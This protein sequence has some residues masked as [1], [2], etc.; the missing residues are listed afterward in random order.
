MPTTFA[1]GG[2]VARAAAASRRPDVQPRPDRQHRACRRRNAAGGGASARAAAAPPAGAHQQRRLNRRRRHQRRATAEHHSGG[3]SRLHRFGAGSSNSGPA[4]RSVTSPPSSPTTVPAIGRQRS[5][6]RP[7]QPPSVGIV[8]LKDV[9]RVEMGALNYN[10]SCTF[11]GGPA[12]GAQ[13]LSTPRHQRPR[14]RRRA[15]APR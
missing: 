8:R 13:H 2:H 3:Y 9:A 12:V 14:R 11:D 10:I 6:G 1:R 15:S 4:F 7:P 5:A